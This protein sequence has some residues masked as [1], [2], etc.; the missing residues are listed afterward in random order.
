MSF[1][2]HWASAPKK[3][4]FKKM[5]ISG[6]NVFSN[7]FIHNYFIYIPIYQYTNITPLLSCCRSEKNPQHCHYVKEVL[8]PSRKHGF[9]V[10]KNSVGKILKKKVFCFWI[11]WWWWVLVDWDLVANVSHILT[12][13]NFKWK[14]HMTVGKNFSSPSKSDQVKISSFIYL[15]VMV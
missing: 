9:H 4:V 3:Y 13:R 15:E 1:K 12:K 14:N 7:V 6:W 8:R 11:W 2:T 10:W 5:T